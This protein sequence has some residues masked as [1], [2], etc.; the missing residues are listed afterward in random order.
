MCPFPH[1]RMK[2]RPV[3]LPAGQPGREKPRPDFG[4]MSVSCWRGS[5]CSAFNLSLSL[6]T[7]SRPPLCSLQSHRTR[8][9]ARR[10]IR[11]QLATATSPMRRQQATATTSLDSRGSLVPRKSR[12][13]RVTPGDQWEDSKPRPIHLTNGRRGETVQCVFK[14]MLTCL[15][16][17]VVSML[18]KNKHI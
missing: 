1:P 11:E 12:K 16:T 18:L 7:Q 2:S 5:S 8:S 15:V 6:S 9:H 4:I 14:P 10:P 17:L 13:S 3:P